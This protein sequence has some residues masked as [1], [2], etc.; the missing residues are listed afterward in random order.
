LW[1]RY[2]IDS[3]SIEGVPHDAF[4]A[5]ISQY[6]AD[7][8]EARTEVYGQF[9]N[10]GTNQFIGSTAVKEAQERDALPDPGAPLL[11]G[12]DVA[13]FGEDKSVIAFRKGRDAKII[14]WQKFK[15][16]DTVRL[17]GIVADLAGKHHV[18]AIFVDGNGVGGGVVDNLKA[19]GY[20]V[21]EVQAGAS[22]TDGDT[23]YNK[24]VEIWGR[25]REWITQGALPK[26]PELAADLTAPEYS[27][28]PSSNKIQ[29]EGKDRMK[30]R[31]QASPDAAEAL[32]LTFAQPVAR[33]DERHSRSGGN[34]RNRQAKD[35]DYP[36]FGV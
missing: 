8:D 36:M 4:D 25:M 19:W 33:V 31:G 29:L 9:P 14:P 16:I 13:R 5:I 18:A 22:A 34:Q 32:A 23:Y 3:R 11:M 2:Q 35:V 30:A 28:H 10:Q 27:F 7:S 24:R 15:G 6:G 1:R 21:V 26:D 12:V 20:K 17:A